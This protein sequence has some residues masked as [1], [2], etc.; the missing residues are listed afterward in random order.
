MPACGHGDPNPVLSLE[1]LRFPCVLKGLCGDDHT[2][3]SPLCSPH[4]LSSG[5]LWVGSS[6]QTTAM[7]ATG[8][9]ENYS[10]AVGGE[11]VLKAWWKDG[12]RRSA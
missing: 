2:L 4:I 12:R 9:L 10:V 8:P 11:L 7:R 6:S 1:R 3:P 5:S